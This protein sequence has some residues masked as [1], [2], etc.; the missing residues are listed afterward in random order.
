MSDNLLTIST[1]FKYDGKGDDAHI[2]DDWIHV[3]CAAATE[4]WF[5]LRW[6]DLDMYVVLKDLCGIIPVM[7]QLDS[8]LME[9]Y[10]DAGRTQPNPNDRQAW[11]TFLMIYGQRI[12]R[13]QC[14]LPGCDGW[15]PFPFIQE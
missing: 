15:D 14:A 3:E 8:D 11:R 7:M 10:D 13:G 4:M 5:D 9:M 2:V 1:Q 6:T 12:I